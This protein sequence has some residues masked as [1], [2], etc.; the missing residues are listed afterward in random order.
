M[1]WSLSFFFL[2]DWVWLLVVGVRLCGR[3]KERMD[4]V[5]VVV[6]NLG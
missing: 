1:W 5:I 6:V 4:G 3:K 2:F